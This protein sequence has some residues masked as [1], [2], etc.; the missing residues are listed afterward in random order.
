MAKYYLQASQLSLTGFRSTL[1]VC[2]LSPLVIKFDLE[3]IQFPTTFFKPLHGNIQGASHVNSR[4][5]SDTHLV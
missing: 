3:S 1:K 2:P 5:S 4:S